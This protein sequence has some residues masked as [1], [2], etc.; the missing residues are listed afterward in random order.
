[1]WNEGSEKAEWGKGREGEK[2]GSVRGSEGE[3]LVIIIGLL[4]RFDKKAH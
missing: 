2:E 1:L 3:G 4:A